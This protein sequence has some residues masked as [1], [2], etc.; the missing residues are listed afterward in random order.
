MKSDS[1]KLCKL[2]LTFVGG[3][4]FVMSFLAGAIFALMTRDKSEEA[5]V[6]ANS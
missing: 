4:M 5:E 6:A 1:C 3:A 2:I